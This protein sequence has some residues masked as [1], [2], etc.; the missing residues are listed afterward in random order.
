MRQQ[1]QVTSGGQCRIA[2]GV[3]AGRF[4]QHISSGHQIQIAPAQELAVCHLLCAALRGTAALI[5]RLFQRVLCG[6]TNIIT[7]RQ[8]Q[9]RT[10]GKRTGIDLNIL[11]RHRAQ[12]TTGI[13]GAACNRGIQRGVAAAPADIHAVIGQRQRLNRDIAFGVQRHVL[14][15]VERSRHVADILARAERQAVARDDFGGF[16]QFSEDQRASAAA[17]SRRLCGLEVVAFGSVD[18]IAVNA[19]E[20]QRVAFNPAAAVGDIVERHQIQAAV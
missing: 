20:L 14:P 19:G 5:Q 8:R 4:R 17:R 10:A 15:S 13:D 7:R 1:I 3:Q 11:T 9:R 6:Q 16:A 12:R 18:D 2:F